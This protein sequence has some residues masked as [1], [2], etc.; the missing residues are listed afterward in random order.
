MGHPKTLW[1]GANRLLVDALAREGNRNFLTV[2]ARRL[3]GSPMGKEMFVGGKENTVFSRTFAQ[4][5]SVW[6]AGRVVAVREL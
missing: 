2:G 4:R 5:R 3:S 1:Y 6:N